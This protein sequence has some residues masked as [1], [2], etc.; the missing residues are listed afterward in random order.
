[1]NRSMEAH[2]VVRQA[3]LVCSSYGIGN[4]VK[5][6][7]PSQREPNVYDFG[8][9]YAHIRADLRKKDAALY[10]R[11]G[12]LKMLDRNV[13][14]KRVPERFQESFA[15]HDVIVCFEQR[16]F[17]ICVETLNARENESMESVLVLNLQTPDN[18]EEAAKAGQ[19]TLALCE[20]LEAAD[21]WE[22]Q[23]EDILDAFVEKTGR[24]PLYCICFY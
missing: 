20:M 4:H 17:D 11:N 22:E 18:A 13:K 7:G 16:V 15:Q 3:G 24:R 2:H 6:P 14:V 19:A 23:I 10:T 8:T 1:M 12:L 5:L 21:D 9:P